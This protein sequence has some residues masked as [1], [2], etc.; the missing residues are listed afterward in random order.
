MNGTQLSLHFVC[1]PTLRL[2]AATIHE[3]HSECPCGWRGRGHGKSAF[4]ASP[5]T[6]PRRLAAHT[7]A[8]HVVLARNHRLEELAESALAGIP[9][10]RPQYSSSLDSLAGT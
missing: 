8:Y 7:G 1:A 9:L 5:Y 6:K 2:A 10:F 4:S 3:N